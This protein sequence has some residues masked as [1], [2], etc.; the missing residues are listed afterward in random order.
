MTAVIEK[1]IMSP[2][3]MLSDFPNLLKIIKGIKNKR[4]A[5]R[6]ESIFKKT[7]MTMKYLTRA[8]EIEKSKICHKDKYLYL[9]S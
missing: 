4:K 7:G 2:E 5:D 8:M 3:P 6:T 9:I 1:T